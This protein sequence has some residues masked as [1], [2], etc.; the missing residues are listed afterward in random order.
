MNVLTNHDK[1]RSQ[2]DTLVERPYLSGRWSS[3]QS[4]EAPINR[5]NFLVGR[6]IDADLVVPQ[7]AVYISGRHFEIQ[8]TPVG[9]ALVDLNSTNGTYLNNERIPPM[10]TVPLKN[11]DIIRVGS[12]EYGSS[13]GLTFVDPSAPPPAA[14]GFQTILGA[15]S[16][17]YVERV[18]I[19]RDPSCDIVLESPTVAR[20]HAIIQKYGEDRHF[21]RSTD[22]NR[23]QVNGQTVSQAQLRKGD[24]VQIGPHLLTYDGETLVRFD[25]L[26]YRL[27]VVELSKEVKTKNGPLRIL[28]DISLTIMPREFV[29][30]VGGSGAGKSTLLDALNGFRPAQGQVLING[31]DLYKN[32]DVFRGQIGYVPQSEILPTSLTVEAA[33]QYAA[34]LR[35]AADLSAQE[36]QERISKALA[37]VD[38][39][40]PRIRQTRI[41]RLSGGQRK[42]VS[43]A[44]ELLADPKIFFLDEP[45]SG[46]DPGLEKKLM[47]TLRKM[48]DE[49]RTIVLITHATDNIVQVDHVAF[50]SQGKLIYFGP[51]AEAQ[52]FFEVEEFADIYEKTERY[53][54]EW[55][56]LFTRD[57]P[58]AYE[59]YVLERQ[60]RG[61]IS[62]PARR[63]MAEERPSAATAVRQGINQFWVLS[64]R[65]FRLILNDP[66]AMFVTLFVMPFVGLQQILVTEPH[67]LV[68]DPNVLAN[69][70]QAAAVASQNYLPV[71][72]VHTLA[73]SIAIL[74]FLV[75]TFGGSQE[76][77][78]ERSIY[79]RERMVNLQLL[80][81]IGS[82]FF[83]FGGLALV[84]IA[85]YL[86]VLS[87]DLELPADGLIL[88]GIVEIGI[89]LFLTVMV[90]IATGLL[91]SAATGNATVAVYLVLIVVFFQYIFG[92]AIHDLRDT[93]IEAQSYIA[94]TRWT[95][96][97]MGTT[98]NINEL[99]EASIVCGNKFSLDASG[100][101]FDPASGTLDPNSLRLVETDESVCTNRAMSLDEIFLPYGNDKDDLLHFW[102]ILA[103]MGAALALATVGLVKRLDYRM[104]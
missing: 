101:V 45:A 34:R 51:P 56:Q 82:K 85:I 102:G 83:V 75:G 88:P 22:S 10:T 31:Q 89:T 63:E 99:A 17:A 28:D 104:A 14:T 47:Y 8:R 33:L 54:D 27:D 39:N 30:L 78:K 36:R 12:E 20:F 91:I 11:G 74:A 94:A 37:T 57:N 87:I 26:G 69:P 58:E 44:A 35:L 42:R 68:G 38:M 77:L 2:S 19:G 98:L 7:S 81:Y 55:R 79:L 18:K 15:T 65:M 76:L 52:E 84:Q 103:G 61:P 73:F 93:P 96:L 48:A 25:S 46:L 92:G 62:A 1:A 41:S 64:Q 3:G 50:L 16:L 9:Y 100:V 53:G 23:I 95:T 13:L 60:E 97:A 6:H 70:V 71:L 43:I 67:D 72:E 86:A 5:D 80:P 40:T 4:V 32:Y 24:Q 21:I 29:A 59:K 90:G 49:G 66:I